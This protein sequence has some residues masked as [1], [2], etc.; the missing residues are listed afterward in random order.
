MSGLFILPCFIEIAVLIATGVDTAQMPHSA[1]LSCVNGLPMFLSWEVRHKR[2][3]QT[4]VLGRLGIKES[5]KQWVL[6]G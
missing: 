1:V 3:K 6:G 2:V 4:V 5:N